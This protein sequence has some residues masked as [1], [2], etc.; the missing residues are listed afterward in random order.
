M[1]TII[2]RIRNDESMK[3]MADL[4]EKANLETVLDGTEEFTLFVPNDTAF[5]RMD[6][7]RQLKDTKELRE[8]L[9]YHLVPGK[10]SSQELASLGSLDTEAGKSLTIEPEEGEVVIDNAKLVSR[11]IQCSNGVIHV[12]DN[13]FQPR[14]SGWYR[15]DLS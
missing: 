13:V 3:I 8:T 11:D 2:T 7:A 1:A 9:K 15:E 5:D 4:L 6:Y 10:V 12:I 14:L